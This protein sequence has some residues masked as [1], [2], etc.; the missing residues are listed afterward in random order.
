MFE[1]NKTQNDDGSL[2]YLRLP[3][4]DG[5]KKSFYGLMERMDEVVRKL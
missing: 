3:K 4:P 2:A 1:N 5:Q